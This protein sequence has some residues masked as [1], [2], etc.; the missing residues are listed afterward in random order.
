[1]RSALRNPDSANI[2][3][4]ESGTP[5]VNILDLND[6]LNLKLI[7]TGFVMHED[8]NNIDINDFQDKC[9]FKCEDIARNISEKLCLPKSVD[10]SLVML[11]LPINSKEVLIAMIIE[12][13]YSIL[14]TL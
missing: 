14:N 2:I 13:A 12:E 6:F 9:D 5:D 11:H 1:M 10:C 7:F 8:C 3:I 4:N